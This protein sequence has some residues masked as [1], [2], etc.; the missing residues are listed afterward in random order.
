MFIFVEKE[1]ENICREFV[2]KKKGSQAREIHGNFAWVLRYPI[3][4]TCSSSWIL[5]SRYY[6]G[7]FPEMSVAI[8]FLIVIQSS[9]I[10]ERS[11]AHSSKYAI[12]TFEHMSIHGL[13]VGGMTKTKEE[14]V[15]KE[16]VR[17]SAWSDACN[18]F[19]I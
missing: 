8:H 14:E 10:P 13:Q 3:A 1:H 17:V 12:H 19:L 4:P 2:S 18:I 9:I 6:F 15:F 5:L 7:T 16:K 11:R